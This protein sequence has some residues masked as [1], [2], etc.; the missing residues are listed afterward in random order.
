[1]P[2]TKE[3]YRFSLK[4]R[5]LAIG[6]RMKGRTFRPCVETLP[7]S[8]L[9]GALAE[10]FPGERIPAVGFLKADSYQKAYFTYSPR[11]RQTG[12]SAL[13]LTLEYLSPAPGRDY[14]EADVYLPRT[15]RADLI[16][17]SLPLDFL[18]GALRYKGFG[19]VRLETA[20]LLTATDLAPADR[21]SFSYRRGYFEG[22]IR[23]N[24]LEDF[25]IK[26]I[27]PRFGYLFEPDVRKPRTGQYRRAIFP[28]SLIE[29]PAFLVAT[30]YKYDV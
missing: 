3:F 30:E 9:S 17:G 18:M 4:S 10:Y 2:R 5:A 23:E 28:G 14:V 12:S 19:R 16:A 7:S 24:E 25:G 27:A 8:T 15:P 29:A 11:D 20:A 1:V 22:E 26:V 6:Q 21:D 13:P